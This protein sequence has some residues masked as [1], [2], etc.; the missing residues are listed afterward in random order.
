MF[1]KSSVILS[2]IILM[3]SMSS[4][5]FGA[6]Y[7]F[8]YI[9]ADGTTNL[10]CEDNN[11]TTVGSATLFTSGIVSSNW[12]F[13][14]SA[15]IA[16]SG[17]DYLVMYSMSFGADSTN[18]DVGISVNDA[19]PAVI[20]NQ[21]F[22]SNSRKEV[23]NM[24]GMGHVTVG[25]G[26]SIKLKMKQASGGPLNAN[27]YNVQVTVVK[28]TNLS[29]GYYSEMNLVGSTAELDV[30]ST[31]LTQTGFG[32]TLA[33]NN[34]WDLTSSVLTAEGSSAGTYLVALSA[35]IKVTS[36]SQDYEFEISVDD[37]LLPSKMVATRYFSESSTEYGNVFI[38][39]IVDVVVGDTPTTLRVK[40]AGS[41]SGKTVME[42][43]NLALHKI[44]GT[45]QATYGGMY[46]TNNADATDCPI[47]QTWYQ[48]TAGMEAMTPKNSFDFSAGTLTPTGNSAGI[49]RV[50]YSCAL[51]GGSTTLTK[52]FVSV[53]VDDVEQTDLT[54][55]RT[56][57]STGSPGAIGGTGLITISVPTDDVVIK[58]YNDTNTDDITMKY[59]DLTLSRVTYSG[60]ASLPVELAEFATKSLDG[61][62]LV[63]WR[64]ASETENL[65]FILERKPTNKG[66]F[67]EIASFITNDALIG[68]GSKTSGASYQYTDKDVRVGETYSY[69]LS[70]VDYN[71]KT[72]R[73]ASS[74]VTVQADDPAMVPESAVLL[75][76]YP[77][78]F[79]PSTT[80]RYGIPSES[81]VSLIVYDIAGNEIA[82]L[83]EGP[84]EAGWHTA[85]WN[86]LNN[87]GQPIPTGVYL[88]HLEDQSNSKVI[89]ISYLK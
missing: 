49:Y 64:T 38:C 27:P 80:L 18:W 9:N 23:G 81:L 10:V 20:Y 61:R 68:Q 28:L 37:D 5:L 86:G 31:F 89:K 17:G 12:A 60:D 40:S 69:R 41:A 13:E 47:T 51:L 88:A 72:T 79:N 71:N 83:V 76:A 57:N 84:Q 53:F 77:N 73:H 54:T 50:N 39:G 46:I 67:K 63:T 35:S 66:S 62:V 58:I 29:T 56:L 22:I 59:A 42:N 75:Q 33:L 21:R 87:Q 70:D 44:S 6:E 78:P 24:S 11:W 8:M 15:L 82:R 4:T 48:V 32:N 45:D 3:A 34:D 7:A 1:R 43:A 85:V 14:D 26:Q 65:G 30:G 16:T 36:I 74:D 52:V 25:N 2:I 19:D 55:T